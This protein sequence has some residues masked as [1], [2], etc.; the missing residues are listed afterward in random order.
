MDL[1]DLQV[2]HSPEFSDHTPDTTVT[3]GGGINKNSVSISITLRSR[4]QPSGL[5]AH[6]HG[7]TS[8]HTHT[9]SRTF[10]PSH[11]LHSL[12]R[13]PQ[14]EGRRRREA[15]ESATEYNEWC[16]TW[17]VS[18]R[19]SSDRCNMFTKQTSGTHV[20]GKMKMATG[21]CMTCERK[22]GIQAG[23]S[24]RALEVF[25]RDEKTACH[26]GI[27]R[28]SRRIWLMLLAPR[29]PR[30]LSGL[31]AGAIRGHRA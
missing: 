14:M 5:C 17:P 27:A 11:L 16:W 18:N 8:T 29:H 13:G 1:T 12:L 30:Q 19:H 3:A 28:V 9:F 25:Q 15:G 22:P 4:Q 26:T 20:G 2:S 10:T 31:I 23:I 24:A 6:V 21:G 7:N